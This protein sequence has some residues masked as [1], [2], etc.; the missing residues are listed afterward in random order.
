MSSLAIKT[1]NL[2]N[3]FRI[4][5][6]GDAGPSNVEALDQE[7]LRVEAMSPALVAVDLTKL[8]FIS[9][10][11]MVAFLRLRRVLADNNGVVRLG[12]AKPIIVDA[13]RRSNLHLVLQ[14]VDSV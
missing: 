6:E 7:L 1:T 11:G 3:G 12:G 13:F 2:P 5:L 8:D 10:P 4:A 14:F 9:T